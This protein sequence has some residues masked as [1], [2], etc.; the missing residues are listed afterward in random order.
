MAPTQL[1][2][3][4]ISKIA[5][6]A[7][8]VSEIRDDT[9]TDGHDYEVEID[10]ETLTRAHHHDELAEEELGDQSADQLRGLIDD[11]NTDQAAEL[12]ALIW[13][14]RGDMDASD[15][16]EAIRLA[17]ERAD[18]PTSRYVLK[19]PMVSDY[20]ETGL[21]SVENAKEIA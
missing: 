3:T 9:F 14:G 17:Q 15:W 21:D 1:S 10:M 18:G 12:V 20:I 6:M 2:K 16:S 8:A 7:R 4:Q 5:E 13:I 11:L 19:M